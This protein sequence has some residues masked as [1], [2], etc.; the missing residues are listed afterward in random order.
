MKSPVVNKS[1]EVRLWAKF[2]RDA[3]K[4]SVVHVGLLGVLIYD[5]SQKCKYANSKLY[6]IE[7]FAIGILACSLLYY[8]AR[9]LYFSVIWEPVVGTVEQQRL[10]QFEDKDASFVVRK[11]ESKKQAGFRGGNNNNATLN[12]SNLNCSY[13]D[14]H[15]L[16]GYSSA[17]QNQSMQF[18]HSLN[19]SN[20]SSANNTKPQSAFA[21]PYL[22]VIADQ[23][24][25][26]EP[27]SLNNLLE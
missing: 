14:S 24:L 12:F 27:A 20:Y 1:L 17:G 16:S 26:M 23:D 22:A 6:W 11:K 19:M 21:S 13:N 15:N 9:Y 25:F 4:W 10:L 5:V 18:N 2:S 8:L 7:Y 3:L